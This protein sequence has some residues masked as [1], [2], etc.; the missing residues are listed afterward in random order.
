MLK[1]VKKNGLQQ[2][3]REHW[4]ETE[5]VFFVG[6]SQCTS[7]KVPSYLYIDLFGI[8]EFHW[9]VASFNM[10]NK[11]LLNVEIMSPKIFSLVYFYEN[12][13]FYKD[14]VCHDL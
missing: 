12:G 4:Q 14:L 3:S 7:S 11:F 9:E 13:G 8:T 10:D 6:G 2:W 1:S 5:G